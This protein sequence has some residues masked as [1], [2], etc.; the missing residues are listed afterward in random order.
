MTTYT[1]PSLPASFDL[2]DDPTV[3]QSLLFDEII[4]R[5]FG[6]TEGIGMYE[7]IWPGVVALAQNWQCE[8]LELRDGVLDEKMP[9]ETV[10]I[11]KWACLRTFEHF[12]D[13]RDLPKN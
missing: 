1:H 3:R 7:R 4:E 11:L 13:M 8:A 2:P 6:K 9:R 12:V 5:G 10:G